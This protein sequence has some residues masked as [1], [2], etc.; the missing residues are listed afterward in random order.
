MAYS[1]IDMVVPDIEKTFGNY[2]LPVAK[3]G[4]ISI[5]K[6]IKGKY[7]ASIDKWGKAFNIPSGVIIGFIATESGGNQNVT[8]FADPDI[9]GLMQIS[10]DAVH[11]TVKRWSTEVSVPLPQDVKASLQRKVPELLNKSSKYTPT[12]KAKIVRLTGGDADFNIMMG[13][14]FLRWLLERY[15]NTIYG[16]QLNKA[17]VAYNAGAYRKVLGG[18]KPDTSRVDSADLATNKQVPSE[19][20]N[21]LLKMFGIDGFLSLIY[22]DKVI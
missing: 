21:Y 14:A 6:S 16:G 5:I 18:T 22:K 17:M 20:R 15:S 3:Q 19:S 7:G 1:K 12:L 10:P 11:D 8:S 9:K 2:S 4:N 13:T